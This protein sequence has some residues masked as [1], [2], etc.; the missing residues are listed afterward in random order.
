MLKLI[1]DGERWI[2]AAIEVSEGAVS[3]G[4]LV[5]KMRQRILVDTGIVKFP[6]GHRRR[7]GFVCDDHI[8]HELPTS[9]P[10]RLA[11]SSMR[12]GTLAARVGSFT[13]SPRAKLKSQYWAA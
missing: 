5:Q 11:C 9:R 8:E 7:I 6:F 10:V 1:G 12:A 2:A 3:S 4:R 13:P